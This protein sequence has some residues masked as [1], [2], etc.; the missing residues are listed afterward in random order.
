MLMQKKINLHLVK[1]IQNLLHGH[2]PLDGLFK[3]YF[4][5]LIILMLIQYVE[6]IVKNIYVLEKILKELF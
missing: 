4:H 3:V 1:Q 6:V 2:V 5:L